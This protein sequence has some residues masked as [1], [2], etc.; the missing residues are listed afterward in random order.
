MR[1]L[2]I[3]G[4]G[5]IA[6]AIGTAFALAP[7]APPT[8][9]GQS[10]L[11]ACPNHS[12][13]QATWPAQCP[14]CRTVLRQV[15]SPALIHVSLAPLIDM[16]NRRWDEDEAKERRRK[17]ELREQ[18]YSHSYAYPPGGYS[19]TYPR[20]YSY[21]YPPRTYTYPDPRSRYYDYPR[22]QLYPYDPH[23]RY[24]RDPATGRSYRMNPRPGYPSD[25]Y[26]RR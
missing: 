4:I 6:V 14:F 2:F 21:T 5:I 25:K 8:R 17:E 11:Y 1:G 16:D 24:Y 13:I 7:L 3:I 15:Q 22:N 26:Y 19:Y 23:A 20:E 12:E 9:V 18:Y 10:G